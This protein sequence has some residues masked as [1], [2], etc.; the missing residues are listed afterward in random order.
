L[1]FFLLLSPTYNLHWYLHNRA[2]H[3]H[4]YNPL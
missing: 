3:Y 1:Y 2:C 4:L